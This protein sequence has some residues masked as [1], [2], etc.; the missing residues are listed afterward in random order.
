MTADDE[1]GE[2][3]ASARA[4]S[5][6]AATAGRPDELVASKPLVP[7]RLL[8]WPAVFAGGAAAVYISMHLRADMTLHSVAL[9]GH[10][11][12][13]VVGFGAVLTVDF[14]GAMWILGRRQFA[15]VARF[16]AA[17]H[18][19]IWLGL[20]GLV[21]SGIL[22]HPNLDSIATRVK[23]A[24]VLIVAVNGILALG[25]QARLDSGSS[26]PPAGGLLVRATATVLVSQLGWWGA[27]LI[28]FSNSE[29]MT[30]PAARAPVSSVV[31]ESGVAKT[32]AGHALPAPASP[33]TERPT[34]AATGMPPVR[35]RMVV[36][37]R[38][39]HRAPPP[40][41]R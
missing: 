22:L 11:M 28:G 6:I 5:G 32:R 26:R 36:T 41:M 10:I 40:A 3:P 29:A 24:L 37:G 19:L 13:L 17:T 20:A 18:A 21:L 15:D 9:F 30:A 1:S 2:R 39:A 4:D 38:T 33:A 8:L 35:P 7:H 23:L 34:V 16:G 12:S 25:V 27:A 14:Q 31:K